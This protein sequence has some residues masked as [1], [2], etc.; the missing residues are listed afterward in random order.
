MLRDGTARRSGVRCPHGDGWDDCV[1][2]GL[3]PSP[4]RDGPYPL[5]NPQSPCYWVHATPSDERTEEPNRRSRHWTTLD[6]TSANGLLIRRF[7]GRIPGGAQQTP[8]R[9][10]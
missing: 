5:S 3:E 10:R 8:G 4:E 7:W 6:G 1:A 2:G 9:C